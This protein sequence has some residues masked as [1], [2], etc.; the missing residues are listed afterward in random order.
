MTP[1]CAAMEPRSCAY[2]TD[3]LLDCL[4]S[5]V[6]RVMSVFTGSL[7][8]VL[9]PPERS[10]VSSDALELD[11]SEGDGVLDAERSPRAGGDHPQELVWVEIASQAIE[12]GPM[13]PQ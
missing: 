5:L 7:S 6:D 3:D 2:V 11:P 9:D 4:A 8:A 12:V 1:T 10:P 13:R